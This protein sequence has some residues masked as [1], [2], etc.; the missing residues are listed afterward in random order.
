MNDTRAMAALTAEDI[1]LDRLDLNEGQLLDVPANPRK[2]TPYNLERLAK[3]LRDDPRMLALRE[4]VAVRHGDRLVVV[5][6]NARLAALRHMGAA[7]AP[8]KVLPDD[9]PPAFLRAFVIKDNN[10]YGEWDWDLLDSQWDATELD[11]WDL[12]RPDQ[13]DQPEAP[14]EDEGSEDGQT[15]ELADTAP[16]R[17]QPGNLWQMGDHRLLCADCTDPA[18]YQRL[19]DGDD[20][21]PRLLLTDPPYGVDY[22][23]KNRSLNK[24]GNPDDIIGDADDPIALAD[25]LRRSLGCAYQ[26]IDKGAAIY[27]WMND[28]HFA[29]LDTTLGKLGATRNSVIVWVKSHFVLCR[30]DYHQQHEFC[31]YAHKPGGHTYFIARRDQTTT[32]EDMAPQVAKMG[33][34]QLVNLVK[35][36]MEGGP[37]TDVWRCDKPQASHQHPTMKPVRLFGRAVRNSSQRGDIVLDPFAGSGT[38][39]ICCEQLGRKARLIEIAPRHCD[40]ILDRWERLTK[41]KATKLNGNDNG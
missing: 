37:Q 36:L 25:L 17:C 3:S 21:P 20:Q 9:T 32:W 18:S 7:T 5:G 15:E 40:G 33:K 39:A 31:R 38:T 27:V 6:G 11:N 34:G 13:P 35:H 19:L 26:R 23:K 41:G 4:L 24:G 16:T 10:A 1:P 28:R 8:V 12:Q 14:E 22:G 30:A 2:L 29:T